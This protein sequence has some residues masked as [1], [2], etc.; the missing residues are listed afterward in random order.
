MEKM[1][2]VVLLILGSATLALGQD[3]GWPRQITKQGSTLIYY[4]PQVDA[5]RNFT[6]IS[7]RMA[8]SLTP[9]GGKEVVGVK[10]D[11]GITAVGKTAGGDMYA[12]H[13]GNVYKNTGSG[14]QSYDNGR[15][16]SVN[17]PTPTSVSAQ[18]K[19][20]THQQPTAA[21]QGSGSANQATAQQ[22]QQ[23]AQPQAQARTQP[24]PQPGV[25]AS[26]DAGS[27]NQAAAQ[28]LA[29]NAQQP[30]SAGSYGPPI[31]APS[32]QMQV[33]QQEA[34]NRQRGAQQSASFAQSLGGGGRRR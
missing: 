32:S 34:Q 19:A 23:S 13:D 27:A 16:N 33:L 4:Q 26:Q 8:F 9:S 25:S 6:D 31:K 18:P 22:Q 5:W 28:Q 15:W 17:T 29:Q 30:A 1:I 7:W 20:H 12:T 10:T 14:W 24:Y 21:T 3:P 2:A 11:S